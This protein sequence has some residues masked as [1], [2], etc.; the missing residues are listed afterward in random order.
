MDD[1]GGAAGAEEARAREL[2]GLVVLRYARHVDSAVRAAAQQCLG[3]LYARRP[4]VLLEPGAV[5]SVEAA[6]GAEEEDHVALEAVR[7]LAEFAAGGVGGLA[8]GGG[9]GGGQGDGSDE[10]EQDKSGGGSGGACVRN[11]AMQLLLAPLLA[12]TRRR[13]EALALAA[14]QLVSRAHDC[15]QV[16][17]RV[18]WVD[19]SPH[20]GRA[21]AHAPR[22]AIT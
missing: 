21:G 20:L 11:A 13:G 14:A 17:A 16:R 19:G 1:D 5:S 3:C 4:V 6:L 7:A 9:K 10:D 12:C 18:R 2:L 8:G 15:G 22:R